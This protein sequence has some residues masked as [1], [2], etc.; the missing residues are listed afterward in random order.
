MGQAGAPC[1]SVAPELAEFCAVHSRPSQATYNSL[2]ALTRLVAGSVQEVW[3]TEQEQ[4][5]SSF[6]MMPRQ[7]S[8]AALT[9]WPLPSTDK[10]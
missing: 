4:L 5:L 2:S 9:S 6:I 10:G 1:S 3:G 7:C 8:W